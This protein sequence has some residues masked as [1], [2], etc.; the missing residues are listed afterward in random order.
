[1]DTNHTLSNRLVS[2]PTHFLIFFQQIMSDCV[3]MPS[4]LNFTKPQIYSAISF[5]IIWASKAL[6]IIISENVLV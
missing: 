5:L 2:E 1:M 3:D 4:L 6:Y